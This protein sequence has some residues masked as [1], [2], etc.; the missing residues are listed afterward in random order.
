MANSELSVG[1]VA[2][3][4]S[5]G[6]IGST[7]IAGNKVDV[8]VALD[9]KG[10]SMSTDPRVLPISALGTLRSLVNSYTYAGGVGT[11]GAAL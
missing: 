1:L 10:N 2:N 7:D 8:A 5:R 4:Y 6:W 11:V 3:D 9:I